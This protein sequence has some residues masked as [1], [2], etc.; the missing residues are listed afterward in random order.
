MAYEQGQNIL[1]EV[2]LIIVSILF[3][4]RLNFYYPGILQRYRRERRERGFFLQQDKRIY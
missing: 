3:R 4:G 2:H 1:T